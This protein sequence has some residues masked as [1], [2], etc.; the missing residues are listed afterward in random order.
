M[1]NQ[2]NFYSSPTEPIYVKGKGTKKKES[3]NVGEINS[4]RRGTVVGIYNEDQKTLSFGISVCCPQDNF[5]KKLGRQFASIKAVNEPC[6]VIENV[7]DHK[8][9]SHLFVENAISIC[10]DKNLRCSTLRKKVVNS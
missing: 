6:R 9:A 3:I 2:F 1:N 5:E 7:G 4:K 8:L 10:A